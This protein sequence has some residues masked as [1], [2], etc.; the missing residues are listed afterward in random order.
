M[1][2]VLEV[3]T[4]NIDKFKEVGAKKGFKEEKCGVDV[5]E[6]AWLKMKMKRWKEELKSSDWRVK[7]GKL[8][9]R[10]PSM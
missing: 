8:Q 5:S 1:N 3:E 2:L 4:V 6:A 9:K 7:F 10:G